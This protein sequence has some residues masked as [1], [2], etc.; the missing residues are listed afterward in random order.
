MR[1]NRAPLK[2]L[3]ALF[4]AVALCLPLVI[5]PASA[6]RA[7]EAQ[8]NKTQMIVPLQNGAFVIFATET[9]PPAARELSLNFIEAE[10]KPN[11][12]Q[13][14]FVDKKNE[15]YFGYELSVEPVGAR[16]FRVSVRPLSAEYEQKLRARPSF[17]DRRLHP[18]FNAAA[19]PA[20]PLTIGD[21]GT[22]ALDV[23]HNP[24]TG[25]KIVDVITIS[26]GD[27]R[28]Q[29]TPASPR[30]PRDFTLEDV[31]LKVTDYRLRVAGEEVYRSTGGCAG[32]IIWFSLPERGRFVFSLIPRPGFDFRKVG[33][34]S[35]NKISFEWGGESFEWESANAVVGTG[36]NWNL[37]VLHDPTY[38][39]DLF[40][41]QFNE[42]R[43]N[44]SQHEEAVRAMKRRRERA[45]F[46][47]PSDERPTQSQKPPARR[48]RIRVVIGAADGTEGLLPNK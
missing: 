11:H 19:F 4:A 36:G 47:A 7:N 46:D 9:V 24:R 18:S 23:L 42:V 40:E 20:Q 33:T 35:H 22:F 12:V 8:E 2:F 30:P 5:A 1:I 48:R 32:A 15:L 31:Q 38:S 28:L 29:N 44:I 6:A 41:Q 45:E 14:V 17:R 37:W 13:R 3:R 16:Q 10:D 27:P 43:E 26:L 25:M 39:F 21:G 34:V